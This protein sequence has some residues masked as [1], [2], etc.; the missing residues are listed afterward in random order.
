M[1]QWFLRY[2]AKSTSNQKIDKLDDIKMK[3]FVAV[4]DTINK[5]RRRL[6]ELKKIFA[7]HVS[8]EGLVSKIYKEL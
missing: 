4:N 7:N 5:E 1:W 3:T 6:T 8:D 2:D